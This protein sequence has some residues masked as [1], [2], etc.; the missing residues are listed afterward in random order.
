MMTRREMVTGGLLG[1]APLRGSAAP[2]ATPDD[3][4]TAAV[5]HDILEE[6]RKQRT[7]CRAG[8]CATIEQ[9]RAQQR[10]FL[11]GNNK[12]P[13]YIDVGIGPWEDVYDWHVRFGQQLNITRTADGRY[14]MMFMFTNLVLR[15]EMSPSYIGLGYDRQ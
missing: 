15:P 1:F 13:D 2:A 10:V 5:L 6:I 12:Y 14:A 4:D 8:D 3:K 9:V 11:K 7:S